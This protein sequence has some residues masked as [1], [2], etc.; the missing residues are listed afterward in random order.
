MGAEGQLQ[1]FCKETEI[2]VEFSGNGQVQRKYSGYKSV[3]DWK[4]YHVRK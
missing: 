3:R 4:S 1:A 2:T